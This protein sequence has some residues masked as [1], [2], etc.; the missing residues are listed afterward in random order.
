MELNDLYCSPNIVRVIKCGRILFREDNFIIISQS[1]RRSCKWF[2]FPG[3]PTKR[4]YAHLLLPI[5]ATCPAHLI[6]LCLIT[7]IIFGEKCG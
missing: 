5:H 6:R 2:L 3:L 4:F 7:R 1:T